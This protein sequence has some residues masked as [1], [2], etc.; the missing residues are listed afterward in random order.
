MSAVLFGSLSTL[1]DTSEL[2]R[3]AFND[4][5]ATH[6]LDWRW[7]HDDYVKM[8]AS[9]GGADRV[10]AYAAARGVDVDADAVH[11]TK[12]R[13]FQDLLRAGPIAP[14]PGV[15]DTIAAAREHGHRL[16]FVT[17]T[18]R[19]NVDA[20]LAALAPHV[21]ATTFDL[22]VDRGSVRHPKPDPEAYEFALRQLGE[23]AIHAVAIEDNLGGVAAARGAGVDCIAFPNSN[24][25]GSDFSAAS[26]VTQVLDPAWV[27]SL[28]FGDQ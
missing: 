21:S 16:G 1:A 25:L 6:G 20:M 28:L 14:R 22:I 10:T 15:V 12:S 17:T 11:E 19:A 7:S 24:T 8:L 18:S 3:R 4:A 23:Q 5:F 26:H 13:L 2:Q 27:L 9:S